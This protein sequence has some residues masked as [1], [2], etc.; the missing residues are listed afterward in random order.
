MIA[1][2]TYDAPDFS[3]LSRTYRAA[4]ARFNGEVDGDCAIKRFANDWR[5]V[6]YC[7]TDCERDGRLFWFSPT[8]SVERLSDGRWAEMA[9]GSADTIKAASIGAEARLHAV[10]IE[11]QSEDAA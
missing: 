3:V 8:W 5:I 6:I 10:I 11:R 1:Q 4:T 7:G 9:N 2:I